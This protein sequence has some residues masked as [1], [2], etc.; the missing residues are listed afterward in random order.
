MAGQ[1]EIAILV[2]VMWI[3]MCSLYS[4]RC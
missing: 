4:W 3:T 2:L 1:A